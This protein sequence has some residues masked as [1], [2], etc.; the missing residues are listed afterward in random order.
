MSSVRTSTEHPCRVP[1]P[2]EAA[3]FSWDCKQGWLQ[4]SCQ[5]SL[6]AWHY[7]K[8]QLCLPHNCL[9]TQH[10]AFE[11]HN[12][13]EPVEVCNLVQPHVLGLC[14]QL[15]CE[16]TLA[17]SVKALILTSL[18]ELPS[19]CCAHLMGAQC[20]GSRGVPLFFSCSQPRAC[21]PVTRY[22]LVF[23]FGHLGHHGLVSDFCVSDSGVVG[24][25]LLALGCVVTDT[26]SSHGLEARS[27]NGAP[28]RCHTCS[29]LHHPAPLTQD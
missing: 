28:L 9:L 11:P 23:V 7:G 19:Y 4:P 8:L 17:A 25:A 21:A 12:G 3:P 10:P 29:R 14:S 15:C 1:Q 16:Y 6:V 26:Q 22:G 18:P 27:S 2:Q 24:P 20:A 13:Q 5:Q